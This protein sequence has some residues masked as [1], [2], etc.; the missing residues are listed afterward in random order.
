MLPQHFGRRQDTKTCLNV[1]AVLW[2]PREFLASDPAIEAAS[3]E[4]GVYVSKTN[5]FLLPSNIYYTS[6][7]HLKCKFWN[8]LK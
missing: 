6:L 8:D 2:D 1:S 4:H 7:S 5:K 3:C